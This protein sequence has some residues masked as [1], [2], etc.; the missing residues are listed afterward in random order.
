MNYYNI[1]HEKGKKIIKTEQNQSRSKVQNPKLW[2]FSHARSKAFLFPHFCMEPSF[3]FGPLDF[4][5][6]SQSAINSKLSIAFT[7]SL[8]K[9]KFGIFFSME[10][11]IEL[12]HIQNAPTPTPTPQLTPTPNQPSELFVI[13]DKISSSSFHSFHF[14]SRAYEKKI[15]FENH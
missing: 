15:K 8:K 9:T 5:T 4:R 7:K 13:N 3:F 6:F 14:L 10:C 11:I 12:E 2:N 1:L